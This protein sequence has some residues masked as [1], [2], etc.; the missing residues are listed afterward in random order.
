VRRRKAAPILPCRGSPGAG[1]TVTPG[2]LLQKHPILARSV[3]GAAGIGIVGL[4]GVLSRGFLKQGGGAGSPPEQ[5]ADLAD[6]LGERRAALAVIQP[7]TPGARR[8]CAALS[9]PSIVPSLDWT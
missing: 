1:A 6:H 9:Q 3:E 5:W 2:T 7:L 8:R 4:F